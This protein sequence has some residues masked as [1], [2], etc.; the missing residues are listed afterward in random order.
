[1]GK[2]S[3]QSSRVG[4]KKSYST[5]IHS[6]FIQKGRVQ[7]IIT[8]IITNH[9]YYILSCSA[10]G[11]WLFLSHST[12]LTNKQILNLI[13]KE[14]NAGH[15]WPDTGKEDYQVLLLFFKD[16]AHLVN[17]WMMH[18]SMY[19]IDAHVGEEQKT[20]NAQEEGRPVWN[21]IWFG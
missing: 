11:S 9:C 1:M 14:L 16:Q 2:Q 10:Q 18:Y 4:F 8:T 6:D 21:D 3:T 20:S 17:L 7:R 12:P 19:P 13:L 5:N 15:I